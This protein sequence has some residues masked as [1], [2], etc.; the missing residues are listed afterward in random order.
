MKGKKSQLIIISITLLIVLIVFINSTIVNKKF[1]EGYIQNYLLSNIMDEI[2]K[3][4]KLSNG[5]YIEN[6]YNIIKNKIENYCLKK[7]IICNITIVK[8]SSAP[9]NLTLLNY[10]HFNYTIN[11]TSKYLKVY[12]RFNCK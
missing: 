6:R 10:T 2:C 11:Y 1:K 5:S 8:K 12:R 4:G 9:T 3:T 7:N